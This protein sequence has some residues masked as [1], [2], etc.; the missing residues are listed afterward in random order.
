[1]IG[2]ISNYILCNFSYIS[3]T[4]PKLFKKYYFP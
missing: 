2:L 1:M 3:S 4:F